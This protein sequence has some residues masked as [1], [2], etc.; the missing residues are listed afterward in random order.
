M[1]INK[2]E[3]EKVKS[4]TFTKLKEDYYYIS[5]EKE[6][7][8]NSISENTWNEYSKIGDIDKTINLDLVKASYKDKVMSLRYKNNIKDYI[9]SIQL[10]SG[11]INKL[12]E[13]GF[14]KVSTSKTKIIYQ[15]NK[16]QVRIMEEFDYLIIIMVKQ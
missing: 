3:F 14:K 7:V 8:A 5:Y 2:I 11:F 6:R 4:I 15:N 16:Y 1:R 9:S 10:A 12:E 13:Q